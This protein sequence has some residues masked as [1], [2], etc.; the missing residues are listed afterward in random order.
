MVCPCRMAS[1]FS[2]VVLVR[3]FW[4]ILATV[5][6]PMRPQPAA[7]GAII[8][9]QSRTAAVRKI[10]FFIFLLITTAKIEKN[11]IICNLPSLVPDFACRG[12]FPAG[13]GGIF[14]AAFLI[15]DDCVSLI[16]ALLQD[17][18][19]WSMR[20]GWLLRFSPEHYR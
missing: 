8:A 18:P 3:W 10:L 11:R 20:S 2:R 5:A 12:A 1:T 16:L 15:Q 17:L 14:Y 6:C 13:P 7:A 4:A 9:A 19:L